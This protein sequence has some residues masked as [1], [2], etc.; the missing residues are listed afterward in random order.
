[1]K[2]RF[3]L[4]LE[5]LHE[6]LNLSPMIPTEQTRQVSVVV[7]MSPEGDE[8]LVFFL[9]G[10]PSSDTVPS[11]YV[12]GTELPDADAA[13]RHRFFSL[14]D[15]TQGAIDGVAILTSSLP[16]GDASGTHILYQDIFIP[17][18]SADPLVFAYD[19]RASGL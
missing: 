13:I 1:M 9:G 8:S 5:S 11:E 14:V 18:A 10:V 16:G 6:R 15:R 19:T 2:T 12:F 3:P 7:D 4:S 17:A